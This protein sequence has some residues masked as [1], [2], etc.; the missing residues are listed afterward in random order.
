MLFG[1]TMLKKIGLYS[2]ACLTILSAI[3][4]IL[5]GL[6]TPS[7]ERHRA[8][9]EM[10]VSNLLEMPV[11]VKAVH[12]S[13]YQYQPDISLNG[14]TVFD[15][16]SNEPVLQIKQVHVLIAIPTSLWQR[17]PIFNG[18]V[19]SGSSIHIDEKSNGDIVIRGFPIIGGFNE[20][21]YERETK[22]TDMLRSLLKLPQLMLNDVDL[23]YI[24]KTGIRRF[25]SLYHLKFQN[26]GNHHQILGKAILRQALRTMVTVQ[27]KWVGDE[28]DLNQMKADIY[29]STTN[30][31]LA[32]WWK[33]HTWH[34]WSL[35]QGKADAT[36]WTVWN[37]G[38]FE[39]VQCQFDLY[40][41]ELTSLS[42]HAVH[43]VD[44]IRGDFDFKRD[45]EKQIFAG[46]HIAVEFPTHA[47][48]ETHFYLTLQRDVTGKLSSLAFQSGYINLLDVQK[49]LFSSQSLLSDAD[50]KLLSD[51]QLTGDIQDVD[52]LAN[53]SPLDFS[54]LSLKSHFTDLG[55]ASW[56][57]LPSMQHLT[58]LLQWDGQKGVLS[59]TPHHAVLQYN[60]VF[61]R[62]IVLDQLSGKL[63]WQQIA[64]KSWVI[65]LQNLMASNQDITLKTE[66]ALMV[67]L[68]S[69]SV[70]AD[71]KASFSVQ[72]A[73]HITHYLPL[74]LFNP[75]LNTWL[76]QAF[77]AGTLS[78]GSLILNGPLND[79]PFDKRKGAFKISG[80]ANRVD[81]RFAPAWPM[82]TE[83]DGRITFA[84]YRMAVDVDR[85]KIL[86]IPIMHVTGV[87]P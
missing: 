48:P 58:G 30:L 4:I 39:R 37:R 68:A 7:L 85:A 40:G 77:K 26:Q 22:F 60:E 12:I 27:V 29:L 34:G 71:L 35:D 15:K 6:L 63:F 19:I 86:D 41:L 24:G 61:E 66:G 42:D 3:L 47:W 53:D 21:P 50:R 69:R 31:A 38:Q 33:G 80:Y 62:P 17:K 57:H 83:L 49:I 54:H 72:N 55:I 20:K 70:V 11:K 75:N 64:D 84:G 8:D 59:L 18:I 67:P 52:V 10:Q 79:F 28:V 23:S 51:L 46:E 81:M 56:H 78:E 9:I 87:I 14:V 25:V 32:E 1:G 13:W 82:L 5:S 73:S 2:F 43:S 16:S 36:I 44:R 65:H 76:K 74:R 45:G